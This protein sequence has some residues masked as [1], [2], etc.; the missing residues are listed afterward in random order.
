[1]RILA[2]A[3]GLLIV[4]GVFADMTNTM[5]ATRTRRGKWWLTFRFYNKSWRLLRLIAQ[6]NKDVERRERFLALFAPA[7]L[8]MLLTIW[9]SLQA[10]G[11]ALIWWGSDGLNGSTN[12]GDAFYYSGVVFFT[13]GFGDIVPA[14]FIPRYGTLIEAFNGVLSIALVISYL[15]SLLGAYAKRE[16]RVMTLD[17]GGVNQITPTSLLIARSPNRDPADLSGFFEEWEMWVADAIEAHSAYPMLPF[18]RSHHTAQNWVTALDLV[19]D[20]ALSC[21]VMVT[22]HDRE[23]FWMI[24]RTTHFVQLLTRGAD[25]SRFE[26][27]SLELA[28]QRFDAHYEQLAAAGFAMLPIDQARSIAIELRAGYSP[29]LEFLADQLLVPREFWG[30]ASSLKPSDVCIL[31]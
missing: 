16:R 9:V 23:P 5:I 13:L 3:L 31:D 22:G 28:T 27:P 2:S 4:I 25:L 20:V 29:G 15:P 26:P 24:R 7:S 12:F 14:G 19:T 10:F 8:L 21:Q 18:F 30:H 17:D 6:R 1:M 11:Y